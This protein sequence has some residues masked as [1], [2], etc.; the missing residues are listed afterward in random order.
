[1]RVALRP[2]ALDRLL[3]RAGG[4]QARGDDADGRQIHGAASLAERLTYV[5]APM[6]IGFALLTLFPGRVGGSETYVRGL[7][8]EYASG[9]GPTRWSCSPTAT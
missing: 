5:S 9:R 4:V 6:R 1:M 2:D 8:G 3:D 7:L